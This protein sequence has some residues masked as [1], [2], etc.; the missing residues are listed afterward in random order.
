[1]VLLHKCAIIIKKSVCGSMDI[2]GIEMN[3][4]KMA[5]LTMTWEE[6]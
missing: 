6:V 5:F 4:E 1:M 3:D 2:C